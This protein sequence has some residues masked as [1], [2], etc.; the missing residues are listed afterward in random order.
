M[1]F[2]PLMTTAPVGRSGETLLNSAEI[3]AEI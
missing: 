1:G 2:I 3:A